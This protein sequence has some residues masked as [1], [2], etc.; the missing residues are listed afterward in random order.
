[1]NCSTTIHNQTDIMRV[2]SL[3]VSGE[4]EQATEV[5]A[6]QPAEKQGP[7]PFARKALLKA[8]GVRANETKGPLGPSGMEHD[9][10]DRMDGRGLAAQMKEFYTAY[11]KYLVVKAN[12]FVISY[13]SEGVLE[14]LNP[15][16][17]T[18]LIAGQ[19]V[20]RFFR[21]NMVSKETDYRNKVRSAI[22]AGNPI[23][24]ELRLQTRRSARFRGDEVFVTHWTPLKDENAATHWVVIALA[25][26]MH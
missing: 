10:L 11:S 15:A 4:M 8:F 19:E 24:V 23:S 14:A 6:A 17:N 9:V 2:L 25:S 22:R 5:T 21:Q 1:V 3:S 18:T 16:N 20:F 26:T 7:L 12:T 13:Y